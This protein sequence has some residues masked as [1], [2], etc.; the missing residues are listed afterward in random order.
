MAQAG[1]RYVIELTPSQLGWG[2]ERY[3]NSR[4]ARQGEAYLAIPR[5]YAKVYKLF[6]SNHTNGQ[7]ILGTNIYNCISMDGFLND[8]IKSQ[9]CVHE[10]DEFAKQFAGNNNLKLLGDWY[11]HIQADVGDKIEVYFLSPYDIQLTLL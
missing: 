10:G 3:T 4:Q 5:R 6:N 11:E 1:D 2:E 9:G 7:D 8:Q